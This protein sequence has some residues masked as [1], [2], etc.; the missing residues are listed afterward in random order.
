MAKIVS[1]EK[2]MNDIWQHSD[3]ARSAAR[4]MPR[5]TW[6]RWLDLRFPEP[7]EHAFARQRSPEAVVGARVA[8]AF[9]VIVLLLSAALDAAIGAGTLQQIWS[10]R[11]PCL[12]VLLGLFLLSYTGPF[13]HM[14]PLALWV[15]AACVS[16]T[17]LSYSSTWVGDER[18]LYGL[19]LAPMVLMAAA[20]C[21]ATLIGTVILMALVFAGANFYWW[22]HF[23]V[24]G[25]S[26]WLVYGAG[27]MMVA[28][29]GGLFLFRW[30]QWRRKQFLL[31]QKNELAK[32][33]ASQLEHESEKLRFLV[34]LDAELGIANRRSF[35]RALRQEWRRA[36]R[37]QY[38]V[39]L[40]LVSV[41][42]SGSDPSAGE[43]VSV[44]DDENM[45]GPMSQKLEVPNQGKVDEA[46]G[47][48]AP[49]K[50]LGQL[51]QLAA[52]FARRPGDLVARYGDDVIAVLLVDTD[53]QNAL[54]VARRLQERLVQQWRKRKMP[55]GDGVCVGM[56]SL[57]P[58][59]AIFPHDLVS[60]AEEGLAQAASAGAG[61]IVD[62]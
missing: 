46:L 54:L 8:M 12:T 31:H 34:A 50:Q 43:A 17:F 21:Q 44:D 25:G 37:N 57:L 58:A 40:L 53:R 35:D 10:V 9:L 7:L 20:L 41:H 30:E 26:Q 56:S 52:T 4:R 38:P 47:V 11:L 28:V 42:I 39:A 14:I 3:Q 61:A 15:M 55:V 51:S 24:G 1:T 23:E 45:H 59:P 60:N 16:A 18:F 2:S 33:S 48:Q 19:G 36:I 62:A 6:P 29:S 27:F 32:F 5:F 13:A 22:S 49:L